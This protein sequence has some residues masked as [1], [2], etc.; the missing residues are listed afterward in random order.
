MNCSILSFFLGLLFFFFN[1]V[2]DKVFQPRIGGG[3]LHGCSLD[4]V[5]EQMS[6]VFPSL[7]QLVLTVYFASC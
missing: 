2:F 3:A 4:Q 6:H 1:A 5:V 7:V